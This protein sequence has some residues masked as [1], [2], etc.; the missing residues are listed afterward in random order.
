M[1]SEYENDPPPLYRPPSPTPTYRT[2]DTRQSH[3]ES[4]SS[5]EEPTERPVSEIAELDIRDLKNDDQQ[6]LQQLLK[7][8]HDPNMIL[9]HKTQNRP[10]HLAA[11]QIKSGAESIYLLLQRGADLTLTN[12]DG[13]APIHLA[14]KHNNAA[15][16]NRLVK[17]GADPDSATTQTGLTALQIAAELGYLAALNTLLALGA[18]VNPRPQYLPPEG[19]STPTRTKR[20]TSPLYR[21]AARSHLNIVT[22]LLNHA[23]V[24]PWSPDE[25][26]RTLLHHAARNAWTDLVEYLLDPRKPH[27]APSMLSIVSSDKTG[28]TPLHAAAHGGDSTILTALLAFDAMRARINDP[29]SSTSGG[30]A[31]LHVAAAANHALAVK[32][33]LKKGADVRARTDDNRM[34]PLHLAVLGP[35]TRTEPDRELLGALIEAGVDLNAVERGGRTAVDLALVI[36]RPAVAVWLVERGGTVSPDLRTD[37]RLCKYWGIGLREWPTRLE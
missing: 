11:T 37:R 33:L 23:G 21:A 16:I 14:A 5:H 30:Y 36:E 29:M 3:H 8:V 25:N 15:A 26:G 24:H 13:Y 4:V 6:S 22:T 7:G 2:V 17:S 12:G 34:T 20:T 35:N 18:N 31:P 19:C 28:A 9:D 27:S 1:D 32:L 10:L